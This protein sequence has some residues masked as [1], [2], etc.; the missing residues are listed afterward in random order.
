MNI[1]VNGD[2]V[3]FNGSTITDLVTQLSLTGRRLAV[4]VN[5][6]IVPKSEHGEYRLSEGDNVEIVHAIGGG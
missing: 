3:E 1:T 4:E 5:R 6:D 2:N